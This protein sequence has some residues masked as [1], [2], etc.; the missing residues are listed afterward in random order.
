M[1]RILRVLLV[2]LAVVSIVRARAAVAQALV[3]GGGPAKSDC[4]GEWLSAAPNRGA[5]GIDCEDGDPACDLDRSADGTCLIATGICLHMDNVARCTA[6]AIRQ[7]TVRSNP[8]R[9]RKDRS[10]VLPTAPAAPVSVA[11]CGADAV[12]TLPLRTDRKGHQ[13]P[14][15][16]ITLRMVTIAAGSPRKDRDH[17][18]L[19][20][21]PN[22]GAGSCGAN[23]AGGPAELRMVASGSGSDLDVG[24]TGTAHSFGIIA[25][26]TVRLCLGSCGSTA[27]AQCSERE[28]ETAAVNRDTFG[29]PL[30]LL[31]SGIAV[32]VVNRFGS[33]ALTDFTADV[34]TGSVAGTIALA[35][36]A[37]G[38]VSRR[39]VRAARVP[40]RETRGSAT[41]GPGR[42]VPAS[43][44]VSPAY[45]A[46]KAA[47]A[48]HS[49]P[50]ARLR[51][52][53]SEP[54]LSRSR[55]PPPPQPCPGLTRAGLRR[56][57]T[58]RAAAAPFPARAPRAR[59]RSTGSAST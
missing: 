46:R 56:M 37:S 5:T 33:P 44:P 7:V 48:M 31:A 24:W 43:P 9:V 59:R 15:K 32:C 18:K 41:P 30:P 29:A 17:L 50:T 1:H 53:R 25:N 20:C 39:C 12:I 42:V 16:R 19:R 38:R 4:Y 21:S 28:T 35:S 13:K 47:P 10:V 51:A 57:T 55:S 45:P 14:S 49:R 26:A 11:T 54:P 58:A 6:P 23:P 27:N 8:K 2:L 40:R 22:T 34:A 36:Q 3:P 52:S